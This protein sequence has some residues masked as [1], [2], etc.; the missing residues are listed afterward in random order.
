MHEPHLVDPDDETYSELSSRFDAY[1]SAYSTW[2]WNSFSFVVRDNDRIVAG[3]RGITNMGALEV[4]GLWVDEG[5][6]GTG[7]G[8]KVLC[9]IEDEARRRGASRAMLYTFSWQA[10]RFYER[11]GYRV[12]SRFEFPDGPERIDMQKEL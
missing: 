6:R 7:V 1:N 2:D 5:L 9:A 4:R 11:M 12:F 8:G 10:E 3:G